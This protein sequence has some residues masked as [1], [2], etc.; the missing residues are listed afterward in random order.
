MEKFEVWRK[1][2]ELN[3]ALVSSFF[4]NLP[5]SRSHQNFSTYTNFQLFCHI[6]LISIK[7]LIFVWTKHNSPPY[8]IIGSL[9]GKC[10]QVTSKR[11]GVDSRLYHLALQACRCLYA[12]LWLW[13]SKEQRQ[14]KRSTRIWAIWRCSS[15]PHFWPWEML[16][17][18]GCSS[19]H[20]MSATSVDVFLSQH[21]IT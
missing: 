9:L 7:L 20:R 13:G 2:L 21:K 17:S 18:C 12:P 15:R 11:L 16:W 3:Q 6:I 14:L 5:T 10:S 1:S 4:F 8:L 19:S